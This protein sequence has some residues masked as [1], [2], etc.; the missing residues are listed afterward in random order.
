V[1]DADLSALNDAARK[2]GMMSLRECAIEKL[3]QGVTTYQE[4]LRVTSGD[5]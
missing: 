3:L 5:L 4:V 1:A 2:E